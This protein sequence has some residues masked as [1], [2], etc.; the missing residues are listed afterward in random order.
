[1][2]NSEN[3]EWFRRGNTKRRQPKKMSCCGNQDYE[4]LCNPGKKCTHLLAS[5]RCLLIILVVFMVLGIVMFC[6]LLIGLIASGSQLDATS[7]ATV[8]MYKKMVDS[9]DQIKGLISQYAT[10]FPPNQVEITTNQVLDIVSRIDT[11]AGQA[12]VLLGAGEQLVDKVKSDGLIEKVNGIATS[13][14]T[15]TETLADLA[16]AFESFRAPLPAQKRRRS[17]N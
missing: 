10:N 1:M 17:E 6:G 4:A 7:E 16:D 9:E 3:L 11:I 8:S 12:V 5:I 2:Y 15:L 13:V 14:E